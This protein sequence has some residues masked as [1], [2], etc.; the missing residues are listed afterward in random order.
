MVEGTDEE[1]ASVHAS[2]AEI[3]T[4]NKGSNEE[5]SASMSQSAGGEGD[6]EAQELINNHDLIGVAGII[7]A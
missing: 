1:K 5:Q 6:E 7:Q 2:A 4:A 3:E